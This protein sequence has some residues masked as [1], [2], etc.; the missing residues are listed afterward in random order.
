VT[1]KATPKKKQGIGRF[2]DDAERAERSSAEG[3]I[4]RDFR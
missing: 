2:S 4:R 1:K 3:V